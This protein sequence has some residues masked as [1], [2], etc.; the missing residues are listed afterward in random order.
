M[1]RIELNPAVTNLRER[2]AN[3]R[4]DP[5]MVALRDS[6]REIRGPP[7]R[8]ASDTALDLGRRELE[9]RRA[10]ESQDRHLRRLN[11]DAM[12]FRPVSEPQL[13]GKQA[14]PVSEELMSLVRKEAAFSK[15]EPE[16]AGCAEVY[17][18]MQR[19]TLGD[20]I[21]GQGGLMEHMNF[22]QTDI[23]RRSSPKLRCGHLDRVH[24]WNEATRLKEEPPKRPTHAAPAPLYLEFNKDA[25][26]M[27]G[28]LRVEPNER[29]YAPFAFDGQ[30]LLQKPGWLA[31]KK[32][33]KE[34]DDD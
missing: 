25:P 28:S 20:T 5:K 31:N 15:E 33:E 22:T 2:N 3:L 34:E 27:S 9:R 18:R 21:E 14:M 8:S 16:T 19:K 12:G 17:K 7:Q 32:V 30:C 24:G 13:L 29:R 4:F 6:Q 1:Q 23:L 10:R 26:T 11:A